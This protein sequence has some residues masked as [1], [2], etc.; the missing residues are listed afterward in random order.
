MVTEHLSERVRILVGESWTGW[1]L[2]MLPTG[3][4]DLVH[5]CSTVLVL[6]QTMAFRNCF[7][8]SPWWHDQNMFIAQPFMYESNSV[9]QCNLNWSDTVEIFN[10]ST[11]SVRWEPGT[12][13]PRDKAAEVWE[14][15]SVTWPLF[16][17]LSCS[18]LHMISYFHLTLTCT[19]ENHH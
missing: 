17:V 5:M 11:L 14:P 9:L 1:D 10:D 4:P 2:T 19:A 13:S 16:R 7:R 6:C 8:S 15:S 12:L 3:H 18:I